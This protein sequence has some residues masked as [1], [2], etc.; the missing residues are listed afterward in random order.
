MNTV[1]S[2]WLWTRRREGVATIIDCHPLN[3]SMRF[4]AWHKDLNDDFLRW[5][6]AFCVARALNLP[7]TQPEIAFLLLCGRSLKEIAID[8]GYHD[9]HVRRVAMTLSS[10]HPPYFDRFMLHCE[11]AKR[12]EIERGLLSGVSCVEFE[13]GRFEK[14]SHFPPVSL[15]NADEEITLLRKH[16]RVRF[17]DLPREITSVIGLVCEIS[18]MA[19]AFLGPSDA[20]VAVRIHRED[21]DDDERWM[22]ENID[23]IRK[24]IQDAYP[25]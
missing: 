25:D 4:P 6:F 21:V 3:P 11:L 14:F 10:S 7:R 1:N 20:A 8:L 23:D 18:P 5:H 15:G 13:G 12:Y 17:D 24:R 19:L 2:N 22:L 16:I 9:S